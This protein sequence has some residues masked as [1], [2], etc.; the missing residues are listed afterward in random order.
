MISIE[1]IF[2]KRPETHGFSWP[3]FNLAAAHATHALINQVSVLSFN[4]ETE[5]MFEAI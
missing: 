4:L 2:F 5:C 3:H 1:P